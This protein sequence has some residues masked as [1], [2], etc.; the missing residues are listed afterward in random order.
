MNENPIGVI[1]NVNPTNDQF[2]AELQF[3]NKTDRPI[4]LDKNIIILGN[5]TISRLFDIHDSDNKPIKYTGITIKR[6]FNKND[7]IKLD[8]GEVIETST[9]LNKYYD[10]PK[11]SGEF[12]IRYEAFNPSYENQQMFEMTSN[13]IVINNN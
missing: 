6:R 5:G 3:R 10:F 13:T 11:E 1:L 12:T 9:I 7:F 4:Y 2:I 8:A